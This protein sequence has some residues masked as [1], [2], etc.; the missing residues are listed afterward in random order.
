M[1]ATSV[2]LVPQHVETNTKLAMSQAHDRTRRSREGGPA[3]RPVLETELPEVEWSPIARMRDRV[4]HRCWA[5]DPEIVWFTAISA[6]P[7]LHKALKGALL[8]T[9][10]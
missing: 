9:M 6:V 3:G 8:R 7:E 1:L 2:Y 5:T 10:P 4:A